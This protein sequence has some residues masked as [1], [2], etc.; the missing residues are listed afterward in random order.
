MTHAE[1]MRRRAALDPVR[2]SA[3]WWHQMQLGNGGCMHA[4][5]DGIERRG[6][7]FRMGGAS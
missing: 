2:H 1:M 7:T 5:A 4:L 3:A 6:N